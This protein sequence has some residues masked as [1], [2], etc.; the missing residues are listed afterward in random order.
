MAKIMAKMAIMAKTN[1]AE[2]FNVNLPTPLD[3]GN[4]RKQTL[5]AV[6]I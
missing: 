5:Y 4:I 1:H 3:V 2:K 6:T